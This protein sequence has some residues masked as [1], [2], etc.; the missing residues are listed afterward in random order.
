MAKDDNI[1]FRFFVHVCIKG[2]GDKMHI[3][4]NDIVSVVIGGGGGGDS[5]TN[6]KNISARRFRYESSSMSKNV[7]LGYAR[8]SAHNYYNADIITNNSVGKL[9]FGIFDSA[10]FA[11]NVIIIIY[12]MPWFTSKA[13]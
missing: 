6:W 13:L 11:E 4:F 2:V 10:V 8:A 12:R 3:P 7:L 5:W 1:C 9:Q